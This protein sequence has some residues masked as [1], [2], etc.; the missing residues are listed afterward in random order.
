MS[1]HAQR[2]YSSVF[3]EFYDQTPLYLS[4]PDIAFYVEEAR[5]AGSVL[6]LGCGSGRVLIPTAVAGV[7]ITGLDLSESMLAL[8]RRKLAA[9]PREVRDRVRLLHASMADFNLGETFALVTT[10]FRSFQ[11]LISTDEQL[12]CLRCVHRHLADGGRLILDMFQ[13]NPAGLGD[14]EWMRE[15]EDTPETSLP[16]GRRFRRTARITAFHRAEQFNEVEFAV[17]ITYPDGRT[18]RHTQSFPFRYFFPKEVE[19]LLARVGLRVVA[20]Y[21]G[22]DRSPLEND[23]AEMLT[24]AEKAE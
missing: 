11:H 14:P 1:S 23:S 18:E 7:R 5:A 15:R 12:A 22:F 16:D 24:V 20:I 21:G 17:Y 8:C 4:R 9:Q 19:H 6:E 10:P 13:V 3:A 2:E